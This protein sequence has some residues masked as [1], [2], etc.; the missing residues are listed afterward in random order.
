[1]LKLAGK[2]I[3]GVIPN[4]IVTREWFKHAISVIHDAA[5]EANRDT[6]QLEIAASI[7]FSVADKH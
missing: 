6:S 5:R 3:D 1:M 7:I 4:F 2:M